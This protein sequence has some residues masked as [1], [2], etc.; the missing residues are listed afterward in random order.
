[1]LHSRITKV[2]RDLL[3]TIR[4]GLVRSMDKLVLA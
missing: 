4:I 1:V 2:R 3:S